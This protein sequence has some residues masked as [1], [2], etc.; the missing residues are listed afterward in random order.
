MTAKQA[1]TERSSPKREHLLGTAW[2]LIY[3]EGIRAVGIDTILAEAGVAK[4]TLY[5]HFAS[6]D[7]LVVALLQ[8]RDAEI[9]HS[10]LACVEAAGS[11]PEQRFLSV[12]DWLKG[13]FETSEFQGCVFIRALSEYPDSAHVIHRTAWAHK[14]AMMRIFERLGAACGVHAPQALATALNY[15]IDG[16]IVAAHAT[17]SSTPA[18]EAKAVARLMLKSGQAPAS[19]ASQARA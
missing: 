5:N 16:S 11:D 8:R 12:F 17:R 1:S 18:V 14:V 9:Q 15:L 19:N 13:W 2:R 6:K 3:R 10:L 4:M 7:E